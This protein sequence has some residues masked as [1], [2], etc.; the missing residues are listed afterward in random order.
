M[1]DFYEVRGTKI[2]VSSVI[3]FMYLKMKFNLYTN[4]TYLQMHF[5]R[6]LW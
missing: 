1:M 3:I 5:S 6:N 4:V 2:H